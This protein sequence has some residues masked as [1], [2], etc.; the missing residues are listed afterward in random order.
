MPSS[1]Q[2][3]LDHAIASSVTSQRTSPPAKS[4]ATKGLSS[5]H[6]YR[7]VPDQSPRPSAPGR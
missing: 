1:W 6:H 5:R 7:R 2:N 3:Q 4:F